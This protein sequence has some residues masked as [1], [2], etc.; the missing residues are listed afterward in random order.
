MIGRFLA[1]RGLAIFGQFDSSGNPTGGL[2]SLLI[3]PRDLIYYMLF[4][5]L[6]FFKGVF[7]GGAYL[8]MVVRAFTYTA[9]MV[10]GSV[11]F[12]RFWVK[13]S[14]MDSRSVANQIQD[15]GF[16]IPGFRRDP[17]I[18][19]TVLDRYI[20][21]LTDLGAVA[22]GLL[23]ALAD[24]TNALS[25]GTGILLSVMILYK[26]YETVVQQYAMDMNPELRKFLKGGG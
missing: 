20:P 1:G 10:F 26:L 7:T 9:A 14:N 8:W 12:A 23:A 13:T 11:M 24:F 22:V 3:P 2:S 5:P 21:Y 19:S 4:T 16:G 18:L 25:R 6:A 17:R 15:G